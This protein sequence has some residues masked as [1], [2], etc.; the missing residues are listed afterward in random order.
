MDTT[1]TYIRMCE[2]AEE[3]QRL[4]PETF[5][6]GMPNE[7]FSVNNDLFY[8]LPLPD[9]GD[10]L[11]YCKI[12]WLPRQDQLQEMSGLTWVEFDTKCLDKR[13]VF[14]TTKELAGIQ[15]LMEEKFNKVW[16][17]NQWIAAK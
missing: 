13:F 10:L 15:V 2:K 9:R 7:L 16:N 14:S 11:Y 6:I 4:S 5:H 17:G 1:N 8:H 12:V 3:I